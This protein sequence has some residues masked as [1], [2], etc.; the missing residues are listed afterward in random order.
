MPDRLKHIG[1]V[2]VL[3]LLTCTG[4]AAQ[5]FSVASFRNLP[6][7]VTAFINPI[8]DLNGEGCALVKVQATP[9]FAFST[10]LGIVKRENKTG[11]I[12]LYLPNGSK[13][14]TLKHPEWGV[15][16]DYA[17]P[18]KLVSHMTYEMR[19]DEPGVYKSVTS[20]PNLHNKVVT[21][22]D[23]LVMTRVDTL[24]VRPVK[25]KIPLRLTA[26][27]DIS[28]GS[29]AKTLMGGIMVAVMRVHG[30]FVHFAT[31]F[32]SCPSTNLTCDRHGF[33]GGTNPYYTDGKR[34]SSLMATGGAIHRLSGRISLFEGIGY[35]S[36]ETVW[37]LA[38][39]EGGGY[40]KNSHYS[41]RGV[42]FEVGTIVNM[43]RIA[44]KASVSSIKGTQWFA[45][46]GV[47]INI[48]KL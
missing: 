32:G 24:I 12:W 42:A 30:G 26:L 45:S 8:N 4:A 20:S 25:K 46:I 41:H 28:F 15:L 23:T 19:I 17:F 38:E 14:I 36:T 21:V 11:E 7:D 2:I 5:K 9:D 22:H 34:H 16:R 27:A 1:F 18:S 43:N 31:D 10:P 48:G 39:S 35:G 44:I 3:V 40:V 47:G 29:N 13:K 33:I 6:N 37:Q